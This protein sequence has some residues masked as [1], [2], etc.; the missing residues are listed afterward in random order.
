MHELPQSYCGDNRVEATL[1]SW[2]QIIYAHLAYVRL[3]HYVSTLCVV[4]QY[5]F[6]PLL[7]CFRLTS[8]AQGS[9]IK[10]KIYPILHTENQNMTL[11]YQHLTVAIH[12]KMR[13]KSIPTSLTLALFP[14]SGRST[15][16]WTFRC[17]MK[18]LWKKYLHLYGVAFLH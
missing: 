11:T 18:F 1:F 9:F 17:H 8:W 13:M 3:E 10:V 4:D 2:L 6:A 5:L 12:L 14:V 16:G 7:L 15:F